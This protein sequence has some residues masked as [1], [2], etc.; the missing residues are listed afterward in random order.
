MK[1]EEEKKNVYVE[2]ELP[3]V[4]PPYL[5]PKNVMDSEYT[6]VLDLDE[7]LIHFVSAEDNDEADKQCLAELEDGEND[8]FYL[9]RPFCNKFVSELSKFYEV[10]IFTAAMQDYA[11]WIIKESI[12]PLG[13]LVKHCLYR[14]HCGVEAVVK[15]EGEEHLPDTIRSIKDMRLLGR[16]I[17]KVIIIDNLKENFMSTCPNNGIEIESWYDDL[18]DKELKKLLPF[19]KAIVL[20]EEKDVRPILKYYRDN[21]Q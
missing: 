2:P 1:E 11:D 21:Y 14:Q 8:F 4:H 17:R 7:T 13:K 9:L 12:D 10:V 5:P 16:D 19:L 20:N 18:D 15:Q 6:L 3:V